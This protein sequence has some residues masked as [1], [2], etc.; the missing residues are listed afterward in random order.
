MTIKTCSEGDISTLV[1]VAV[2]SYRQHYTYLWYDDGEKYIAENFSAENF[3][4]QLR[5][6]NVAMFLIYLNDE[7]VGFLKLNINKGYEQ[8]DAKN[9]LEL[10]RIYLLH[11]ISGKGIGTEVLGFVTEFSRNKNKK[12]IWLKVMDSSKATD[13]Y[14]R[15]GFQ[16]IGK[17]QLGFPE[18]K[19]EFRGMH[20]MIRE[21]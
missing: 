1:D 21:I 2:R 9:S 12:Y 10:E 8:Y 11:K 7:P 13:F 3:R 15:A 4:S 6:E 18:M 5:D 16:I 20:V 14:T 17:W 19:I